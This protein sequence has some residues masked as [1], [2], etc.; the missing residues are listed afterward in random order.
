MQNLGVFE[1]EGSSSAQLRSTSASTAKTLVP[2]TK[3]QFMESITSP[4]PT[5]NLNDPE[6]YPQYLK[7][8]PDSENEPLIK[9]ATN[10][11]GTL[12]QPER[13]TTPEGFKTTKIGTGAPKSSATKP[14][15]DLAGTHH[16]QQ[17]RKQLPRLDTESASKR[18]TTSDSAKTPTSRKPSAEIKAE[19]TPNTPKKSSVVELKPPTTIRKLIILLDGQLIVNIYIL[20]RDKWTN[21]LE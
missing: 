14:S 5:L 20:I 19:M 18:D 17:S 8:T 12:V 7:D 13:F 4:R 11:S 2:S 1:F 21:I 3:W 10:E 16:D 6:S 9:T 15:N